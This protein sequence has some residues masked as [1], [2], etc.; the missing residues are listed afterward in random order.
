MSKKFVY[1][2]GPMASSGDYV[3]NVRIGVAAGEG[4][5]KHGGIPFVPHLSALWQFISPH[6]EYEFWLPM[7]LAWLSKCD[8]L[9]R[10]PGESYGADEEEKFARAVG[11]PV[12]YRLTDVISWLER[13]GN[14]V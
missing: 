14:D 6:S 9:L 8:A 2:A 4:I 7:D 1:V 11:I 5:L 10:L 12:F 3:E 13:E